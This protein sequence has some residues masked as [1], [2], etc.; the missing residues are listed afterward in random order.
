MLHFQ[1]PN[2]LNNFFRYSDSHK[3]YEA[4]EVSLYDTTYEMLHNFVKQCD[5][6]PS[7]EGFLF[8]NPSNTYRIIRQLSL[9]YVVAIFISKCEIVVI[10]FKF[11]MLVGISFLNFFMGSITPSTKT[12]I[13]YKKLLHRK[14]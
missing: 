7:M 3:S 14:K 13:Y 1:T 10:I 6:E 11:K 8:I 5:S 2:A 12:A 9:N 4:L